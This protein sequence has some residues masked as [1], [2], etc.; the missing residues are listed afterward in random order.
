MALATN[1]TVWDAMPPAEAAGSASWMPPHRTSAEALTIC[2]G[3][4]YL[5][6][7]VETA[8][9]KHDVREAKSM[10]AEAIDAYSAEVNNRRGASSSRS[11]QHSWCAGD[12]MPP[13]SDV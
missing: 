4:D 5:I 11:I 3:V 6:W 13:F 1:E 10:L 12:R 9:V 8:A 2:A 7:T